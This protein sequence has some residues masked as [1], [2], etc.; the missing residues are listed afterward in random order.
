MG[1]PFS[2]AP[3]DSAYDEPMQAQNEQIEMFINL[4]AP[5]N[6]TQREDLSM[7]LTQ[8]DYKGRKLTWK[9][10]KSFFAI[11]KEDPRFTCT[12]QHNGN[13]CNATFDRRD[14]S[15]HH[16][17]THLGIQPW[18]CRVHDKCRE[19]K[20]VFSSKA[21]RD[22]HEKGEEKPLADGAY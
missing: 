12:L 6:P 13:W 19:R 15:Q 9:Q 10:V 4:L 2:P 20:R 16:I 17:Q 1:S 22:T 11:S 18:E 5:S 8:H 21:G 14:R 7:I 3:S